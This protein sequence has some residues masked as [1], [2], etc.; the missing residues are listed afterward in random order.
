MLSSQEQSDKIKQIRA[1][2]ILL[3]PEPMTRGI[4]YL[5]AKIAEIQQ[6]KTLISDVLIEAMQNKTEVDVV[7]ENLEAEH[8]MEIQG[9]LANDAEV[10]TQKSADLRSSLA[11][12]KVASLALKVHHAKI[13]SFVADG[14]LSIIQHFYTGAQQLSSSLDQQ[15]ELVKLLMEQKPYIRGDK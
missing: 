9:L 8:K 11:N 15:L 4:P 13:E 14:F 7:L 6:V 1:N 12:V 10:K 5:L 3:D 2:R